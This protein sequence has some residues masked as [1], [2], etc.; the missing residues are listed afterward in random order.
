MTTTRRRERASRA[1]RPAPV[2]KPAT[3]ALGL[4]LLFIAGLAGFALLPQIRNSTVLFESFIGASV[5][6]SVWLAALWIR[7]RATGRSL[8]IEV[9]LRPQH[10]LQAIA[11][12]SIFVFWGIYWAPIRDAA[13]LIAAQIVFT[14]AFDMLLGW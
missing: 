12:T 2:V 6:L 7:A 3:G 4:P 5:L 9:S 1:H 11:H 13:P 14:Y 8:H 10:Y